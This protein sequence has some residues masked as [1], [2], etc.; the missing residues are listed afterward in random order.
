M[1][2]KK[3]DLNNKT[4]IMPCQRTVDKISINYYTTSASNKATIP[5]DDKPM[6]ELTI[7]RKG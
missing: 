1:V 2:E 7:N 6:N 3:L 5:A 4:S